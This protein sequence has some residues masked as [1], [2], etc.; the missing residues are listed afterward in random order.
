MGAA[1][2]AADVICGH[3]L[4]RSRQRF[5]GGSSA[6]WQPGVVSLCFGGMEW[7][8]SSYSF[9]LVRPE[10]GRRMTVNI[11]ADEKKESSDRRGWNKKLP[12]LLHNRRALSLFKEENDHHHHFHR[13]YSRNRQLKDLCGLLRRVRDILAALLIPLPALSFCAP[14]FCF[15]FLLLRPPRR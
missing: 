5:I 13:G 11:R 2:A 6:G 8:F 1:A 12:I 4:E 7:F 14:L 10:G 3:H 15:L 9:W